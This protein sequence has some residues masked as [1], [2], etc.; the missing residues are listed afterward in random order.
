[1]LQYPRR[2]HHPSPQPHSRVA[3][4]QH[5][6]YQPTPTLP[7]NLRGEQGG[8]VLSPARAETHPAIDDVGYLGVAT[9]VQ[10]AT[11]YIANR[12]N[13]PWV[14]QV[15]DYFTKYTMSDTYRDHVAHGPQTGPA[16]PIFPHTGL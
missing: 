4:R 13:D 16:P 7:G 14:E 11:G 6:T 9:A 3:P 12:T 10:D 15:A 2:G 8:K 5:P 1:M